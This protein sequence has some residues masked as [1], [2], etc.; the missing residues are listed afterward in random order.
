M[1]DTAVK[2]DLL[3]NTAGGGDIGFGHMARAMALAQAAQDAS[4][5][6]VVALNEDAAHHWRWPCP[7]IPVR[8]G[9]AP[10]V[11]RRVVIHDLPAEEFY[12][13]PFGGPYDS[14]PVQVLIEDGDNLDVHDEADLIV[15]PHPGP[16]PFRTGVPVAMGPQYYPLRRSFRKPPDEG[17]TRDGAV[18]TYRFDRM[19]RD[20]SKESLS[21]HEVFEVLSDAPCIICPPSVIA[22]EAMA[23]GTPVVL[24]RQVG[25]DHI[26]D[27]LVDAGMAVAWEDDGDYSGLEP[28]RHVGGYGAHEILQLVAR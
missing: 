19:L 16:L 15:Y 21:E 25:Y 4:M 9:G 26:V 22:Y 20:L 2:F 17:R 13:R 23:M 14:S 1:E 12:D 28:K 3:I 11:D 10:T 6:C 18:L 27:A 24:H 5:S 7:V 8:P